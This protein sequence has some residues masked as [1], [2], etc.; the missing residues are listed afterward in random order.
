MSGPIGQH[1]ETG[2]TLRFD[3]LS[4]STALSA[5]TK[6]STLDEKELRMIAAE[7][8]VIGPL[9]IT[10]SMSET[11]TGVLDKTLKAGFRTTW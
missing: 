1:V 2:R 6:S 7:Q 3:V 10:G 8:K 5:G 9:S 11:P 4:T